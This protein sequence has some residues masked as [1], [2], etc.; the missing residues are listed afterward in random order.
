MSWVLTEVEEGF[1]A[2]VWVSVRAEKDRQ[3]KPVVCVVSITPL[4]V[5]IGKDWEVVWHADGGEVTVAFENRHPFDDPRPPYV[6]SDGQW[7][8]SGPC[9]VATAQEILY[10]YS[11]AIKPTD[12]AIAEMTIVD[13]IPLIDPHVGVSDV[14]DRSRRR[15]L[16]E[17]GRSQGYRFVRSR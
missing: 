6:I 10:K 9:K 8:N 1:K 16:V 3:G 2:H 13:P 17:G 14:S 4:I 11:V 12:P 7:K 15:D 5:E